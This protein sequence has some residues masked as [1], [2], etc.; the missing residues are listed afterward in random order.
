MGINW[1]FIKVVIVTNFLI[2]VVLMDAYSL[3]KII[4]KDNSI[5]SNCNSIF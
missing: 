4:S 5:N 2:I 1:S 3:N